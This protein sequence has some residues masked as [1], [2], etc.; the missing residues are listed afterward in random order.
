MPLNPVQQKIL[1]IY[2]DNNGRLPSFR[3][4]AKE[5]GVSSTNTVAYHIQQ[6]KKNGYF[7]IDS[8]PN[9][10]IKLNLK[11]ILN[12]ESKAGVYVIL[13][14]TTPLYIAESEN[15]KNHILE[16]VIS[17]NSPILIL[18][19]NNYEQIKIAYHLIGDSTERAELKNHLL[20]FYSEKGIK[21]Q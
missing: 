11:N 6:L 15:M 16:N 2:K 3:Q 7:A 18:I 1:Q 5:L 4:L 12:L 17:D 20:N 13:N 19:K 14:K 9:N 21:I 8:A 10:I